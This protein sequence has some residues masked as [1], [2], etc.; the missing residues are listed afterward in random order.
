MRKADKAG[1]KEKDIFMDLSC[2]KISVIFENLVNTL[3]IL[4]HCAII[5]E[6][7]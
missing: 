5:L 2:L 4:F 6:D 3:L 1:E 7:Y